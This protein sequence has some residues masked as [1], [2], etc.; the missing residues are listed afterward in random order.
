LLIKNRSILIEAVADYDEICSK[1]S[2]KMKTLS[3]EETTLLKRAV[4]MAI[5]PMIAGSSRIRSSI[6]ARCSL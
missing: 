1:N 3:E 6:H 4:D 2:W 5:I